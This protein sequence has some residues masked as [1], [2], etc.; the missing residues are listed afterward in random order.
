MM[1]ACMLTLQLMMAGLL[2]LIL[3][4]DEEAGEE[5]GAEDEGADAEDEGGAHDGV[6]EAE[7]ADADGAAASPGSE[8][9]GDGADGAE[10]REA[11]AA[12]GAPMDPEKEAQD[13]RFCDMQ[14]RFHPGQGSGVGKWVRHTPSLGVQQS[15]GGC[16]SQHPVGHL[17]PNGGPQ[18]QY[19]RVRA[20]VHT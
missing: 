20:S 2:V 11:A 14:K 5:D 9:H 3:G 19:P 12:R 16:Q 15:P 4:I 10:E 17:Q 1:P 18:T 6:A 8:S 7:D 13:A